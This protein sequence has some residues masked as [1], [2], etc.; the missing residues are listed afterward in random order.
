M[1]KSET[2]NF[3][4]KFPAEMSIIFFSMEETYQKE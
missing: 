3:E 2:Y 1:H 4:E